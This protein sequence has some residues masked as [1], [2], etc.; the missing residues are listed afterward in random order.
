MTHD[1]SGTWMNIQTS[2]AKA[3]DRRIR[4][5]ANLRQSRPQPDLVAH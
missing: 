3:K 5:L 4:L 1:G 2:A